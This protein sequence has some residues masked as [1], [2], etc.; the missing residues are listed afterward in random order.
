M[1]HK[2]FPIEYN[3]KY[4]MLFY[5]E[6][7]RYTFLE[8]KKDG[9]LDYPEYDDFLELHEK[10][11]NYPYDIKYHKKSSI[12]EKVKW[13]GILLT[14]IAA[15][16]I[17]IGET[18]LI[19]RPNFRSLEIVSK[20]LKQEIVLNRDELSDYFFET[21]T[22]DDVVNAI[23]QNQHIPDFYKEIAKEILDTN[24][25]LDPELDLRIFYENMK[26]LRV[27]IVPKKD[28]QYHIE[29]DTAAW[30]DSTTCEICIKEEY[31]ED[32]P[33]IAHE[34]THAMHDL[35]MVYDDQVLKI[36]E[37]YGISLE[38]AM[39][40]LIIS[41]RYGFHGSYYMQQKMLNYFI[42][43]T[44]NFNY[45]VYNKKGINGLIDELKDLYPDVDVDYIITY[46]D[47]LTK[48]HTQ[49]I[50][51]VENYNYLDLY[52]ELLK[53][54]ESNINQDETYQSFI[55]FSNLVGKNCDDD[56]MKMFFDEYDEVLRKKELTNVGDYNL[57]KL[58]YMLDGK[59][60]LKELSEEE[61]KELFD[62]YMDM[63]L[64]NMN[65]D[66]LY[67]D[68]EI[69]NR[70]LLESKIY[71]E[72]KDYRKQYDAKVIEMGFLNQKQIDQVS[73]INGI[74]K[75][76]N[77][78]YWV[79]DQDEIVN[80]VTRGGSLVI[81]PF[82]RDYHI[83]TANEDGEEEEKTIRSEII[84][85]HRIFDTDR[86][87]MLHLM[88]YDSRED[89]FLYSELGKHIICNG[90]HF[91]K[92]NTPVTV[93][94]DVFLNIVTPDIMVEIGNTENDQLGFMLKK[95]DGVIYRTC[96]QFISPT[97]TIP[98]HIYTKIAES[99]GNDSFDSIEKYLSEEY[100]SKIP[101]QMLKYFF[102][103]LTVSKEEIRGENNISL[104][105]NN[106]SFKQPS[107]LYIDGNEE[108]MSHIYIYNE[109]INN[110]DNWEGNYYLHFLDKDDVYL[111][112]INDLSEDYR[113]NFGYAS[114]VYLIDLLEQ[115]GIPKPVDNTYVFN[116]EELYQLIMDYIKGKELQK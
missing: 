10:F 33:V 89:N 23:D 5:D 69:F 109:S 59:E 108:K 116:E 2:L 34:F 80:A 30:F 44:K 82:G 61:Q 6:N 75:T 26:D 27:R 102:P 78:Y 63:L 76:N 62:H 57:F 52:S 92:E 104:Y 106:Y 28:I 99:Y 50:K 65:K 36:S 107:H 77:N 81:T 11:N 13:K 97:A 14:V 39:T 70:F 1:F 29:K 112:T 55:L 20:S 45:T 100:F 86:N 7:R 49:D 15:G 9:T 83:T 111:G 22:R 101:Y 48:C 103:N 110:P 16:G 96:N 95:Q 43:S 93:T 18:E 68:Y 73:E 42:N 60:I 3:H 46:L 115:L 98:Y 79:Y 31:A 113:N 56:T 38:E 84:E 4:F 64:S 8:M 105:K 21:V 41:N 25:Q 88:A 74:I 114:N 37:Y 90:I 54:A 24:I 87:R 32:I 85:L 71:Q 53:I 51:V 67:L 40:N 94:A 91:F 17:I 72:S 35:I 47:T 66:T 12:P 19:L 58:L